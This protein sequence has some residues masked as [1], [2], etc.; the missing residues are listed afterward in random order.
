MKNILKVIITDIRQLSTNVVAVVIIMGLAVIPSLYAWFNIL[1]NWD[2]YGESAT[3]N[4]QIA[5]SS[6]DVGTSIAGY[7]IN[8]GDKIIANL[9]EN[10]T[11]GWVFTDTEEEAVNGVRSGEYYACLIVNESFSKDIISFLGGDLEHPTIT[12][13]VN[14]KK[15]AIAPKITNKVK[16]TIKKEVNEAFVGTLAGG[17]VKVGQTLVR[18]DKDGSVDI[19]FTDRIEALDKELVSYIGIVDSYIALID[20]SEALLKAGSKIAGETDDIMETANGMMLSAQSALNTARGSLQGNTD[21]VSDILYTME[22]DLT[23]VRH[24]I[25]LTAS[26]AVKNDEKAA[27]AADVAQW[28]LEN[29]DLAFTTIAGAIGQSISISDYQRD[30]NN[31]WVDLEKFKAAAKENGESI[32]KEAKNLDGS[33]ALCIEDVK[34]LEREYDKSLEPSMRNTLTSVSQSIL[35][36]ER[37][38][39]YSYDGVTEVAFALGSYPDV[40]KLGKES[41]IKGKEDAVKLEEKVRDFLDNMDSVGNDEKYDMMIHSLESDPDKFGDFISEPVGLKTIAVYEIENNGSATAPFYLVL[42][43]WVGGLTLSTLLKP[44][45]KPFYNI[46]NLKNHERFF[47]R[48]MATFLVGQLQVLIVVLGA[49]FYVGIQCVH[50]VKLYLAAAVTSFVF[51]FFMYAL[52]YSFKA[53]GEA[54]SVV[55]MVIQVAGSG[56]TFPIEVLPAPFR[57]VYNL[58]PFK[59]AMGAMREC[60][61]GCFENDYW[62]DLLKLLIFAAVALVIGLLLYYPMVKMNEIIDSSKERTDLLI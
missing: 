55:L 7:E 22:R 6:E 45:V 3:T 9:K 5:V 13:Y 24:L 20:S 16:T 51:S 58:M 15:N 34:M 39:N 8:V 44:D 18:V 17:V 4:L 2:P 43:L 29:M 21:S 50:P 47:G 48:Y 25:A 41:L 19:A 61:A 40:L 57:M 52:A 56:G 31:L 1:S 28:K 54:I 10:K 27:Y 36:V 37:I 26:V 30:Y 14:E 12:Y 38:L 59:Y 49:L 53:V 11:I 42:A 60:I 35:D 33:L 62:V 46:E 23:D 32:E